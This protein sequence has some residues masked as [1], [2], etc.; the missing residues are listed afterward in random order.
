MVG[1]L[2]Q[3]PELAVSLLVELVGVSSTAGVRPPPPAKR[4]PKA[5]SLG[6]VERLLDAAASRIAAGSVTD[7]ATALRPHAPSP[8]PSTA[9]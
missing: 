1:G 9:A 7:A 5:V 2:E 6:D 8:T 4:L 3:V